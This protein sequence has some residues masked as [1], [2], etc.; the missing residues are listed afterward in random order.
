MWK[1]W[2]IPDFVFLYSS[3]DPVTEVQLE[4]SKTAMSS[5]FD[6]YEQGDPAHLDTVVNIVMNALRQLTR[7]ADPLFPPAKALPDLDWAGELIRI[8]FDEVSQLYTSTFG[9]SA[10]L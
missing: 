6:L 3:C 5:S 7:A 9:S 8:D 1:K 2:C 4:L 10:V